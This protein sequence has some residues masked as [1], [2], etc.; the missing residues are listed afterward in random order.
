VN[1]PPTSVATADFNGDGNLDLAVATTNNTIS[2]LLGSG[3]GKFQKYT[4]YATGTNPELVLMGDFN[5][6]GILDLATVND[7]T[8][9]GNTL[10]I[11]LGN[12][13]GTFQSH[14]DYQAGTTPFW[15]VTADL[16]G[17]GRLDF[18]LP[19]ISAASMFIELQ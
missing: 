4:D 5:G 15:G 1:G 13:D 9:T 16:N 14:V 17:D 18:A 19:N 2:V 11:L 7:D 8:V 6:D 12:G 10:S 3:T